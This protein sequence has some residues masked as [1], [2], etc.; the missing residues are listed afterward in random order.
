MTYM[1]VIKRFFRRVSFIFVWTIFGY[2]PAART[3]SSSAARGWASRFEMKF[4]HA[5]GLA[6]G[7]NMNLQERSVL[8]TSSFVP[9]S[10]MEMTS[11]CPIIPMLFFYH[12]EFK[13]FNVHFC[14]ID[15]FI[16][17]CA[18]IFSGVSAMKLYFLPPK[19][20]NFAGDLGLLNRSTEKR[21]CLL[22]ASPC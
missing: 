6:V 22:R 2:V 12:F 18:I 9:C 20:D 8:S 14:E 17:W 15:F 16:S 3:K 10:S 21:N 7:L 4:L 11:S 19:A 5:R 1:P 13:A